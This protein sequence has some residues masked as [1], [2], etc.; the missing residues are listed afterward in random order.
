MTSANLQ[1]CQVLGTDSSVN[2]NEPRVSHP[3]CL[4]EKLWDIVEGLSHMSTKLPAGESSPP[5][6][7]CGAVN[8]S[9]YWGFIKGK[10]D[11]PCRVVLPNAHRV[12]GD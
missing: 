11:C 2:K 7:K 5:L 6:A 3:A 1:S 4:Q 9:K 8:L 12:L 10:E